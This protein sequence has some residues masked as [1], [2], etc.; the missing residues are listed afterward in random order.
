MTVGISIA[1]MKKKRSY[2]KQ[3]EHQVHNIFRETTQLSLFE[4]HQWFI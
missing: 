2:R 3:L 4:S 1:H